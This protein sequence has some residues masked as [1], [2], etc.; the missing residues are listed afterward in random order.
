M[1]ASKGA[2]FS[3]RTADVH[4]CCQETFVSI[5]YGTNTHPGRFK[6]LQEKVCRLSVGTS[7]IDD[8]I[9][10]YGCVLLM[11]CIPTRTLAHQKYL[12]VSLIRSHDARLGPT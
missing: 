5:S 3:D 10:K 11:P 2:L 8:A 1:D 7:F 9:D 12:D 6:Y 4:G